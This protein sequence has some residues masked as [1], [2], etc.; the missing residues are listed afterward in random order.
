[1]GYEN[2]RENCIFGSSEVKIGLHQVKQFFWTFIK[3]PGIIIIIYTHSRSE[4]INCHHF[5]KVLLVFRLVVLP[6]ETLTNLREMLT[7]YTFRPRMCINN[8]YNAG[9]LDESLVK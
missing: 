2:S 4:C 7:I 1:M 8:D 6:S 3:F 9:K 5:P